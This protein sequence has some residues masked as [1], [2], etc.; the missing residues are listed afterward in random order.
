M[1]FAIEKPALE[2]LLAA[3]QPFLEKKDNT[4][5]TTHALFEA[6]DGVLSI[7]ATDNEIGLIVKTTEFDLQ[8]EGEFTANG[9]KILDVIR[10]LNDDQISLEGDGESLQ[11]K[12]HRSK[13]KLPSFDPS[14]FPTFNEAE[15]NGEITVDGQKLIQALRKISPS[16]AN[17][18]PKFELN[19]ALIDVRAGQINVVSTDTK[20]LAIYKIEQNSD[21]NYPI[22]IPKKAI[23]E[24]TKIFTSDLKLYYDETNLTIKSEDYFFYSRV[25]NGKFPDYERIVPK[26]LKQSLLLNVNKFIDAIRQVSTLSTEIK[27]TFESGLIAFETLNESVEEAKTAIEA[28]I[29]IDAPITIAVNSK[30]ILDFLTH[31]QSEQFAIGINEP[32]TP[33]IL[34]SESFSTIVMPIIL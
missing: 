8:S 30:F 10:A 5:I 14:L 24:M 21:K 6:K 7:R 1:K 17:G 23:A 13:Y 12:Q 33:F 16:I 25:I 26:E 34:R 3:I 19:G 28:D 22:I 27:I 32:T 9:K 11:I 2:N 29:A 20:R 18:N 4:L 31:A 15:N